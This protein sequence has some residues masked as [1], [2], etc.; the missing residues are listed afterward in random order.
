MA[1]SAA[2]VAAGAVRAARLERSIAGSAGAGSV[3]GR[4]PIRANGAPTTRATTATTTMPTREP[5][6]L[7][8]SR[9]APHMHAVTT[10][11]APSAH[12]AYAGSRAAKACTAATIA[13]ELCSLAPATWE[14][15]SAG[16]CWAKM[17]TAMPSVN[18][19]MT[20]H[21]MKET[22][23]PSRSTPARTTRMP[24]R[25]VTTTTAPGPWLATIGT[26]TTTIAPVGPDT[27]TCEP[28]KTAAITPATTAVTRPA[29]AL[30][31]ELTPKPSASGSAT[32][33]TVTPATRSP[34]HVRRSPA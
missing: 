13:L 33:P 30:R 10:A 34:R 2:T 16:I 7:R 17:I 1:A 23:R 24:A 32:M 14:D 3:P 28:P 20:G 8:C 11:T 9:G 12:A 31:P 19:S 5:G 4:A 21:G 25:R 6:T 29:S 15:T 27:C 22:A 18:P 26:R